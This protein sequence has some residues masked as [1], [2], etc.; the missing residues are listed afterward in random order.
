[1]ET[2]KSSSR[3]FRNACYLGDLSRIQEAITTGTLTHTCHADIVAALFNAGARVTTSTTE[4]L[5]GNDLQQDPAIV[6][7]Y[8][9]HGLDPNA[10]LSNGEPLLPRL[11]NPAA[12]R[13]LLAA[14]ADPN[15]CGPRG[16][17]PLARALVSIHEPSTALLELYLEYGATLSSEL[18]FYSMRPRVQQAE[19]KTRFLLDKGLD[20]NVTADDW[21]TPLHFAAYAGKLNIAKLLL[22][23]GADPTAVSGGRKTAGKTPAQA[24]ER[25]THVETRMALL[26]LLE[27]YS[28][29]SS[30]E[31]IRE[32]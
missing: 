10:R 16:L 30:G 4:S 3:A 13:E 20:P 7:H 25:V 5:P 29:R 1:M 21:G 19:L 2:N 6:R 32:G 23:A 14:G 27:C 9:D 8:L 22:D 17:P 11:L 28:R 12:A 18:L 24:A 26:G 31:A 15:L